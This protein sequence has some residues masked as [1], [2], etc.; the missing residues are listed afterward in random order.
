MGADL[1]T[2]ISNT[3]RT[4]FLRT[5]K[6]AA[7]IVVLGCLIAGGFTAASSNAGV[8]KSER[9]ETVSVNRTNKGDR[10]PLALKLTPNT[11]SSLVLTLPRPPIGCDPAF[12]R[13][14]DPARAHIFGRCI[15]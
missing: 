5:P 8:A 4:L 12:S 1:V 6:N 15:S 9:S 13:N 3:S 11:S 7:A 2:F 10:L 14:A